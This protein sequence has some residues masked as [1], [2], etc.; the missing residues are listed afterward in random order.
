MNYQTKNRLGL[1]VVAFVACVIVVVAA[2]SGAIDTAA[3][4]LGHLHAQQR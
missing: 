3:S 4:A 2:K 1:A